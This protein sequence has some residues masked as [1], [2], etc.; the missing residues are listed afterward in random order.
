MPRKKLAPTR[1]ER[2]LS[3]WLGSAKASGHSKTRAA[4]SPLVARI[5]DLLA[6]PGAGPVDVALGEAISRGFLQGTLDEFRRTLFI[7]MIGAGSAAAAAYQSK[8]SERVAGERREEAAALAGGLRSFLGHIED[9][10]DDLERIAEKA[11]AATVDTGD[12]RE[13]GRHCSTLAT[14]LDVYAEPPGSKLANAT[15]HDERAFFEAV[16]RWW[17]DNAIDRDRRGAHAVRDRIATAL[18]TQIWAPDDVIDHLQAS[19]K[20]RARGV[21]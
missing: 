17:A 2:F 21:G 15:A 1:A 12:L 14:L 9:E 20:F 11:D 8:S 5:S 7:C 4:G 19:R 13:M 6:P 10:A 3:N 18:W 16:A